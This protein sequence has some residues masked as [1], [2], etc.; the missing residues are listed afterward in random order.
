MNKLLFTLCC[1]LLSLVCCQIASAVETGNKAPDCLLSSV[2]EVQRKTLQQFYGQKVLYIDFWA[3]WCSP[4]IQSFPFLNDLNQDFREKGLQVIA[5]GMDQESE[6]SKSFLA[7]YPATFTVL[8]DIDEKC[9]TDFDV[10][11]MPSSYL[12]DRKG[13]IRH[14]HLGFRSGDVKELRNIIEQLLVEKQ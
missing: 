5:I 1:S 6:D 7:K 10:K 8:S 11:V 12:V 2:N 14:V 13:V 4:C 9:A 3:S